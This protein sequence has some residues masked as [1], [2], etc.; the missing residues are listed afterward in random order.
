MEM[1][2]FDFQVLEQLIWISVQNARN[3]KKR[4]EKRDSSDDVASHW[5]RGFRANQLQKFAQ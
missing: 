2:K 5:I 4:E 3:P 1:F